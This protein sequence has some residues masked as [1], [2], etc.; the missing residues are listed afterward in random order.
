MCPTPTEQI[1]A[2]WGDGGVEEAGEVWVRGC[3]DHE[4]ERAV[5]LKA[6]GW[7]CGWLTGGPFYLLPARRECA[8]GA[9]EVAAASH[10]AP[11]RK[12][13]S[14]CT[15]AHA[16]AHA[17]IPTHRRW[18]S[19]TRA[20]PYWASTCGSTPTTCSE[21]S[22]RPHCGSHDSR[23]VRGCSPPPAPQHMLRR[24]HTVRFRLPAC[25]LPCL[26]CCYCRP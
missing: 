24:C 12:T 15:T 16:R 19:R 11:K 21:F 20:C 13:P 5:E 22:A 2:A 4:V 6:L 9:R 23:T 1:R 25:Y 14:P 3:V 7:A 26:P 17:Q 18:C 10:A 8:G